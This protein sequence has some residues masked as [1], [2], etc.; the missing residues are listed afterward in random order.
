MPHWTEREAQN[1]IYENDKQDIAV[2]FFHLE[3][4]LAATDNFSDAQKLGQG[5][6][7]PVYKVRVGFLNSSTLYSNSIISYFP[8]QNFLPGYILRWT[9]NCCKKVIKSI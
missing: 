9:R 1:L 7:G 8:H 4:I 2:P 3:K 5:G 6:F